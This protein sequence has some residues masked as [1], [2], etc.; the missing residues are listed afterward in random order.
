MPEKN[1]KIKTKRKLDFSNKEGKKKGARRVE[2]PIVGDMV[3]ICK[4]FEAVARV[5]SF[6]ICERWM[7]SRKTG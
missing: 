4:V 7:K 2:E 3:W 1:N 6:R 5:R